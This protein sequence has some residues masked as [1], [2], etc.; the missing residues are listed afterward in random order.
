MAPGA[1][2]GGEA[3]SNRSLFIFEPVSEYLKRK[4]EK[5]GQRPLGILPRRLDCLC[6]ASVE[7]ARDAVASRR[8][9]PMKLT[10][11]QLVPLS[12]A[13]R[14]Q[15]GAVEL[16]SSLKGGAGLKVIGK[17]LH[18]QLVEEI[19]ATDGLPVWRRDDQKGPLALRITA[20][21]LAAIG[22]G[23]GVEDGTADFP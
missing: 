2:L 11:T 16:S 7:T 5:R 19:P 3:S 9:I 6:G 10:D 18:E 20:G 22:A 17:L 8:R 1:N 23:E 4:L 21:G 12:A 13:A 14:H 15:D